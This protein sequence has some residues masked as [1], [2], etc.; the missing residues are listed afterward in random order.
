[1]TRTNDRETLNCH[2]IIELGKLAKRLFPAT[3]TL[4]HVADAGDVFYIVGFMLGLILWGFAILWFIVA[5]IMI[6]VSG[7]FPFNMGWWGF[8][9]PVGQCPL[10]SLSYNI[11]SLIVI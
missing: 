8:I 1:V 6:A 9:F 5:I 3:H 7:R 2:S 10:P 11:T 4:P